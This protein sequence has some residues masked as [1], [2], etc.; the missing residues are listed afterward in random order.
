MPIYA[1]SVTFLSCL[2]GS[3]LASGQ[4][5]RIAIFLSC[6]YGSEQ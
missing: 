4:W 6:L 2:Y 5:I 3:E 1:I